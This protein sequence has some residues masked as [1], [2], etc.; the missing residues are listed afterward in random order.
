M[1]LMRGVAGGALAVAI[2]ALIVLLIPFRGGEVWAFVAVP[3][4]GFVLSA[5]ALYAMRLLA[6]NTPAKPPFQPIVGGVALGIIGLALSLA[7]AMA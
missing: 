4:A 5:G 7:H 3:V 6:T 1:P 2:L